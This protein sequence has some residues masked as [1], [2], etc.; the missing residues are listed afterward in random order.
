MIRT[1]QRTKHKI[2]YNN[3]LTLKRTSEIQ[4]EFS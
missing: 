3:P 1:E 4:L 2:S